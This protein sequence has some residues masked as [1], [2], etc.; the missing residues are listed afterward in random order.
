MSFK[1]LLVHVD[2]T[3]ACAGRLRAAIALAAAHSAAG[4]FQ[5]GV[6]IS[7]PLLVESACRIGATPKRVTAR[8]R[9]A[10]PASHAGVR[11]RASSSG[12]VTTAAAKAGRGSSQKTRQ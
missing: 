4:T 11:P 7:T 10:P 5:P 3:K 8:R 9:A 2:E 12:Q 1:N 6:S